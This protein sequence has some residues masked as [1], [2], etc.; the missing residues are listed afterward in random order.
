MTAASQ[1]SFERRM[2]RVRTWL[3][4][5]QQEDDDPDAAFI[6]YWIALNAA[7]AT[8]G[9]RDPTETERDRLDRYFKSIVALDSEHTVFGAIWTRFSHE[10]RMLIGNK[11]VFQPFWNHHASRGCDNWNAQF[12]S[13]D[14]V[15][16]TAL[17]TR[18]TRV[19]L[20]VLFNRLY[21]LRN[22]LM[23]GGARWK[24]PVNRTQVVDGERVIAFLVPLFINLMTAHP[25]ID[26]GPLEY[27]EV[28]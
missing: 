16:Y 20:N 22:Q 9:P 1:E 4:R 18:D 26:W 23:H 10:I 28:P 3:T 15:V 25:E 12:E 7:Y 21:V 19:I 11:H 8:D 6:F 14:R 5:A 17:G 2:R 13:E 24:S 27:P